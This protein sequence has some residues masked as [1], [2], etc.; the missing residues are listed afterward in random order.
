MP[1]HPHQNEPSAHLTELELLDYFEG[2]LDEHVLYSVQ[3]HLN[4]CQ[5]CFQLCVSFRKHEVAEKEGEESTQSIALSGLSVEKQLNRLVQEGK[6][7]RAQKPALADIGRRWIGHWQDALHASRPYVPQIVSFAVV[8]LLAIFIG[9][10]QYFAWRS[11]KLAEESMVALVEHYPVSGRQALRPSG[12]F[13]FSEFGATRSGESASAQTLEADLQRAI[14]LGEDNVDAIAHLGAYYLHVARDLGKAQETLAL[15]Y[16]KDSANSTLLNNLGV[17]AWR[18]NKAPQAI[19][20]LQQALRHAPDF[21]EAQYNLAQLLQQQGEI[22]AA[23]AAWQRYLAVD[24][25]ESK[26]HIIATENIEK[27]QSQ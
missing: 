2:T 11:D 18:Q 4:S 10:P 3:Q 23:I 20:Y 24:Q 6:I 16:A 17:L 26:W 7:D 19:S 5:E 13:L 1:T 25:N 27:L 15:G 12:G 8:A 9:V 14:D 22:E 21:A